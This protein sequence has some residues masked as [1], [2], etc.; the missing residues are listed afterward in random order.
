MDY[1]DNTPDFETKSEG[2]GAS[3]AE[4]KQALDKLQKTVAESRALYEKGMKDAVSRDQ[5][6]KY[7]TAIDALQ[8]D[9]QR[10]AKK[11]N[12]TPTTTMGGESTETKAD[13]DFGALFMGNPDAADAGT[14]RREYKS[15]MGSYLRMGDKA[16]SNDQVKALTAGI[17][18]QGGYLV[19]TAR[20][21]DIIKRLYETSAMREIASVITISTKS[22]EYPLDRDDVGYEWVGETTSRS[23][24]S[25]ARIGQL[26]IPVHEIAAKPHISQNLLDDAMVDVEGWLAA[27]VADRFARAENSSFVIGNGTAKPRGFLASPVSTADDASRPFGTLQVINSGSNGSIGSNADKLIDIVYSLKAAY[28]QNAR[29]TMNRKM[30]SDIRKLKDAEG[31]YIWQPSIVAGQPATLLGYAITEFADMPDPATGSNSIA[32]GDFRSGYQIVDR[33]GISVL[34]DPFSAKPWVQFYTRKRVGG[35]VIDSDAIRILK[36]VA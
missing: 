15:A 5:M 7:D 9:L 1:D 10:M 20:S 11:L 33:A 21:A 27:K 6:K 25:T 23:E 28:R 29:W 17:D 12:R 32:F 26:E 18:S 14:R 36:L 8:D 22:I 4:V 13:R 30:Q 16:L 31:N 35:S 2:E 19:E 34:R 3:A 24:T